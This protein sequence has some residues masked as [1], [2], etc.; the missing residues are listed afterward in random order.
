MRKKTGKVFTVASVHNLIP[1]NSS[2]MSRFL[3]ENGMT[4]E[5]LDD[6]WAPAWVHE[7]NEDLGGGDVEDDDH[8]EQPDPEESLQFEEISAEDED[9]IHPLMVKRN[10]CNAPIINYGVSCK[11]LTPIGG[12]RMDWRCRLFFSRNP[13]F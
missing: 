2:K 8:E 5:D 4:V 3:F 7:N 11:L 12:H 9:P 10:I 13:G 6:D 1:I